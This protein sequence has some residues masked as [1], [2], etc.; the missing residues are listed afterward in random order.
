MLGCSD[1]GAE[2]STASN[3]IILVH[4]MNEFNS[5]NDAHLYLEEGIIKKIFEGCTNLTVVG[6]VDSAGIHFHPYHVYCTENSF[7]DTANQTYDK[8]CPPTCLF[9]NSRKAVAKKK[10]RD[11]FR[12]AVHT[13][14]ARP[15]NWFAKL[16]TL[17][18]ALL[19]LLVI[20]FIA[21]KLA[22][23]IFMVIKALK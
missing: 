18:Q 22:E 23:T 9:Y 2:L 17:T 14:I 21:P 11:K 3:R 1:F 15:F 12:M 16:P 20:I 4:A 10:Q 19:V 8:R 7:V 6:G 13:N 5:K